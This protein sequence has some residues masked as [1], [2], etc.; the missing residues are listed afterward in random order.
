MGIDDDMFSFRFE[1]LND[2]IYGFLIEYINRRDNDS[3]SNQPRQESKDGGTPYPPAVPTHLILDSLT[4]S[5]VAVSNVSIYLLYSTL[6]D[7][8]LLCSTLLYS[9]IRHRV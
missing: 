8:A 6:L 7:S 3:T 1:L 2:F 9:S 4:S 5:I